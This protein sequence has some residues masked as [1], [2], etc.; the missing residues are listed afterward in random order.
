MALFGFKVTSFSSSLLRFVLL[1]KHDFI[2]C[3]PNIVCLLKIET[4]CL[5]VFLFMMVLQAQ[6]HYGMSNGS[7]SSQRPSDDHAPSNDGKNAIDGDESAAMK[8]SPSFDVINHNAAKVERSLSHDEPGLVSIVVDD[9]DYC[10]SQNV[11]EINRTDASVCAKEYN[12]EKTNRRKVSMSKSQV[13][14]VVVRVS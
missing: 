14:F 13:L 5:R 3:F 6:K 8:T 9:A 11:S 1:W 10:D 4:R 12:N 2:T 7:D